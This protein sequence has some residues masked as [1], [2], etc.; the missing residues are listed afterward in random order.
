MAHSLP[1]EALIK[2][3]LAAWQSAGLAVAG[4]EVAPDGTV[5][6]LAPID[7]LRVASTRE[8]VEGNTCDRV[9]DSGA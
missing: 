7:A 5:R 8:G 3:S 1:T 9:F 2:R 6:I 4:I